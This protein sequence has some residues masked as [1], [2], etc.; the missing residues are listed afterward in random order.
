M[1]LGKHIAF[2]HL[3]LAQL[4]RCPV[5]WCMV[6][7]GPLRTVL[8]ICGVHT[9]CRCQSKRRIWLSTFQRGQLGGH[10]DAVYLRSG[11]WYTIVQSRRFASMSLLPA[12]QSNRKSRGFA[13]HVLTSV[14]GFHWRIGLRGGTLTSPS[15][16]S[17]TSSPC[18]KPTVSPASGH[19]RS[20]VSH[21]IVSRPRRPRRLK[22]VAS[23]VVAS[24][25]KFLPCRR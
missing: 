2:Y 1:D 13:G 12:Q 4:W 11:N 9:R 18:V 20:P 6:W 3:E 22:G 15:A 23:L 5:M 25:K 24:Q 17:R 7:K 16:C 19:P 8:I 21:R 10:V 14:A